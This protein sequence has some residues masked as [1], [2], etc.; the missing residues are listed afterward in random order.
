MS[1]SE[2]EPAER[3]TTDMTGIQQTVSVVFDQQYIDRFDNHS[4]LV[5]RLQI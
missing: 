5:A 1:V 3:A 4:D 2:N